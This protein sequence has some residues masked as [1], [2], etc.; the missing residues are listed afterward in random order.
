MA[1]AQRGDAG[2]KTATLVEL[3]KRFPKEI[4]GGLALHYGFDIADWWRGEK[5]S[6]WVLVRLGELPDS[7]T[8]KVAL[9]DGDWTEMEHV[10]ARGVTEISYL[11]ADNAA[12]N[13]QKMRPQPVLSPKQRREKAEELALSHS[14]H[15]MI[16]AQMKGEYTPPKRNVTFVAETGVPEIVTNGVLQKMKGGSVNG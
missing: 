13:G 9:R 14:I 3:L 6:R 4:E 1:Q 12:L 2:P 11:R 8:F 7:S 16:V 15:D 5:S 10:L